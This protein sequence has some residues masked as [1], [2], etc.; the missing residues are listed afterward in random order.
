MELLICTKC[1]IGKEATPQYFPL[2]NKK[3]NGLDSWC[4]SCRATYRSDVRRGKYRAM[5]C[6]D[7][8]LRALLAT[9]ECAICNTPTSKLVVDHCHKTN[10]VRGVLCNSCNLGLGKF[11]D[12]P[13]LLEAAMLYLMD[14]LDESEVVAYITDRIEYRNC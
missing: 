3:A 7:T 1:K 10:R 6:E 2:H 5:G 13:E 11:K 4:R 12:S 9:K 14:S 8:K